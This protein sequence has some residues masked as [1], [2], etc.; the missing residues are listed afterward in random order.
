MAAIHLAVEF[1]LMDDEMV[2]ERLG[3]VKKNNRIGSCG[4]T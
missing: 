2:I 1:M 4:E 3:K